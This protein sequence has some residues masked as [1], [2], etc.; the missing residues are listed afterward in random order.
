MSEDEQK[1]VD[2]L[3]RKLQRAESE[4]EIVRDGLGKQFM[5]CSDKLDMY[6]AGFWGLVAFLA[7]IIFLKYYHEW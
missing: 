3:R 4:I 1:M 6:R 5:E 7:L 2:E